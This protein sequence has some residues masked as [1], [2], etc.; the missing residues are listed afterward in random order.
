MQARRRRAPPR[1]ARLRKARLRKARLR[2]AR[3]RKA[4]LR[5]ARLRRARARRRSP[6]LRDGLRETSRRALPESLGPPWRTA[7][8]ASGCTG[9][10]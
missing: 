10:G 1:K 5:K 2:K 6:P 4:R 3:L 8:P 9:R 7:T